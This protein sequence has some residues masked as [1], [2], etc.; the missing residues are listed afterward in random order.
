MPMPSKF[1]AKRR[2]LVLA[3]LAAGAS[4]RTAAELAGLHHSTITVWLRRGEKASE[5]SRYCVFR[6]QVLRAETDSHR[7][8]LLPVNEPSPVDEPIGSAISRSP[9]ATT[10]TPMGRCRPRCQRSGR[11]TCDP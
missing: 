1:T 11:E 6:D 3:A 5:G 10:R 9:F 7:P 8:R 2:Q 4:R